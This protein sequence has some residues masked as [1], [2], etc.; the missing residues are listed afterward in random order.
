MLHQ[1]PSPIITPVSGES[2]ILTSRPLKTLITITQCL[3]YFVL[4]LAMVFY[5]KNKT[6]LFSKDHL[7]SGHPIV[8]AANHQRA[9]D[10]FFIL[11]SL[12]ISSYLALTPYRFFAKNSL[13]RNILLRPFLYIFGCFPAYTHH[14]LPYGLNAAEWFIKDG[15]TVFIFPE[16]KRNKRRHAKQTAHSGV[17]VLAATTNCDIIPAKINWQGNQCSIVI[18]K[19][20]HNAHMSADQIMETIYQLK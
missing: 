19:P 9:M 16:G 7:E 10:P 11:A 14:S 2:T 5:V 4:R 17:A 1:K 18:G 13:Y 3:F 12:P 20:H 15:Q 6:V 8:I